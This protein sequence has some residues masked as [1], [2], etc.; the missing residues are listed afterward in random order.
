MNSHD[1]VVSRRSATRTAWGAVAALA[2]GS[3]MVVLT[4]GTASAFAAGDLSGSLMR[5]R[6]FG[7]SVSLVNGG[8]SVEAGPVALQ[9][10]GCNPSLD[11][12]QGTDAEEFTSTLNT[13]LGVI[14]PL[15]D[16]T[17]LVRSDTIRN[18]GM[19]SAT[20]S[21]AEVRE[22]SRVEGLNLLAGRIRAT[23]VQSDAHTRFDGTGWNSFTTADEYSDAPG[24]V[25]ASTGTTLTDL[26]I[27]LNG[28]GQRLQVPPNPAPNTTYTLSG[29][30][31]LV[32]NEQ[33]PAG[34]SFKDPLN[35]ARKVK[36]GID[37]NALHVYIGDPPG[38]SFVGF[39][40]D[41][42]I[43]H[44]ETRL[45]SASGRLSG[46]AYGTRGSVGSLLTSGPQAKVSLPCTGTGGTP[47]DTSGAKTKVTLSGTP[48]PTFL[49]TSTLYGTV[50][51][52]VSDSGAF[53]ESTE[54]IQAVRLLTDSAGATRVSADALHAV[55]RT[56]SVSGG[57]LVSS[58]AGTTVANL[59]ID[60]D[61][62]GGQAPIVLNGEVPPNTTFTLPGIG[63]LVVNEQSCK[64]GPSENPSRYTTNCSSTGAT[65]VDTH[66][67]SLTTRVLH[68]TITEPGNGGALPIGAQV[69]V[70]VAHSDVAF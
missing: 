28:N 59:V 25:D 47:R 4:P 15:P 45:S 60:P 70:G 37:V 19:P 54:T 49:T 5:G 55:A 38:T 14:I 2:L 53:S 7:A 33:I 9:S 30:G 32:V 52:S 6:A 13:V 1:N 43:A 16:T 63:S 67:A 26:T 44:T 69:W 64:D 31:R 10:L 46:F 41:V 35:P 22:R 61:G 50:N 40:G 20:P 8:T 27:D 56:E 24:N 29:I 68:L 21:S 65:G 57:G 18:T 36:S 42:V 66:Y 58:G 12:S 39:T 62:P 3:G 48:F 17:L 23:V 34:S 11:D 51:G